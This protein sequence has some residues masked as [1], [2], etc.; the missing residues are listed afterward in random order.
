MDTKPG[1]KN[2]NPLGLA[3]MASIAL[4]AAAAA[5]AVSRIGP[6]SGPTVVDLNDYDLSNVIY[7]PALFSDLDGWLTD[8]VGGALDAFRRSCAVMAARPANEPFNPTPSQFRRR[9]DVALSGQASG[10]GS[11]RDGPMGRVADWRPVC[12]AAT[13][14]AAGAYSD[15]IAYGAAARAFFERNF[16]PLRVVSVLTPKNDQPDARQ[17]APIRRA[18]GLYTGYFEPSYIASPI[19]TREFSAAVLRRPVDLVMVDLG[20]FRTSLAGQRIAG[21]VS[22]GVLNPY[23]NRTDIEN[24]ALSAVAQ[25]IAF[26]RPNDLFFLQIQGSGRLE[27]PGGATIRIGYD[28]QNGRPYTAIGKRLI[29]RG[30]LTRENVSMQSI[31]EWLETAELEDAAALRQENES[32]VFFRELNDLTDPELGPLGAQGV[33]LTPDRS[34]AVDRRHHGMGAPIWVAIDKSDRRHASL[35]GLYI[36]QD[37]GGAI[38]GPVRGDLFVGGFDAAQVAGGLRAEGEMYVLA[39]KPV[40]ARLEQIAA[41]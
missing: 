18:G 13:K 23:P 33:Q 7:E 41:L 24:G 6:A 8:E 31:L 39:P 27:F 25:P 9:A 34:I 28:G 10:L 12:A 29:E 2:R 22:D 19:K 20:Q 3:L 14:V 1:G 26:L 5:I 40:A 4:A 36:A 38:K 21:K 15:E 37:T 11:G 17:S 35:S 32:Y 30:A 16:S